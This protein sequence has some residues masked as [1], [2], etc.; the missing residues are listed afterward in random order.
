MSRLNN[1]V[2][3]LVIYIGLDDKR[4]SRNEFAMCIKNV[5]NQSSRIWDM[6]LYLKFVL[7][8]TA[9]HVFEVSA[10]ARVH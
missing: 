7:G 4:V 6:H 5:L 2:L 3:F 10:E 9:K 1:L 8:A